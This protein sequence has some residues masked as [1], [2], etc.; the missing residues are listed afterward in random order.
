MDYDFIDDLCLSLTGASKDYKAEWD[1]VRY[2][3]GGKMFAM[4]GGDG[5][6]RAIISAKHT[7]EWGVELRER[8][9]DIAPG[10]YLNKTH[11][12]SVQLAGEV[13]SAVLK[14]LLKGSY[15]LVFNSLPKRVRDEITAAT[16]AR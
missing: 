16:E 15:E 4:V 1:A 9:T 7:P 13:P 14:D 2:M 6:G 5:E 11:W 10:Y 12:S 3:V 8:Y